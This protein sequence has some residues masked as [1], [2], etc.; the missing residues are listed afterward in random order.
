MLPKP[1]WAGIILVVAGCLALAALNGYQM[2]YV[3]PALGQERDLVVHA[4]SVIAAAHGIE[5]VLREAESSERGYIVTG[6]PRYLDDAYSSGIKAAPQYL[7]QLE[8]LSVTN[9]EQRS[10]MPQLA[11][12]VNRRVALLREAL[13]LRQHGGSDAARR[14]VLS[15]V[16]LNTM[17]DLSVVIDAVVSSE[18]RLLQSR[19]QQLAADQDQIR[20]AA[21]VGVALTFAIMV[22][23]TLLILSALRD[24]ERARVDLEETRSILAQAQ[25]METLGQLAGGIAHDFNNMLAVVSGGTHLLRRRLAETSPEIARVLE[26]IDQGVSRATALTSRLLAFSRRRPVTEQLIN[27]NTLIG[28]MADIL[29]YAIG[30]GVELETVLAADCP[31][32][33]CDP[34]QLENAILNLVVNARDAMPEGG[35][36]VIA[37]AKRSAD[38]QISAA[39]AAIS[40]RDTGRGMP[41][42]VVLRAFE[43][44]FTTK[45][46][47]GTGLGLAQVQSLARQA[48]GYVA[49]DSAPGEGTTVTLHLPAASQLG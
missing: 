4:Y 20:L 36:I 26:G 39:H 13:Q 46:E 1:L 24:R 12:E 27:T 40:V 9:P 49:I 22:L 33:F 31:P 8:K 37:T 42:D 28:S 23:G 17:R 11:A 18:N 10:R 29:R 41:P 15:D 25:K 35:R 44:F 21:E 30:R 43:P 14:L 47:K 16:G 19:L 45:G 7:A 32:V 34:N 6:E 38:G 5:R 48:G 2:V 3:A